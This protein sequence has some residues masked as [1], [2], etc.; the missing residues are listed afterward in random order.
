MAVETRGFRDVFER[1]R[2]PEEKE[3]MDLSGGTTDGA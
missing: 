2:A 3:K 1:L